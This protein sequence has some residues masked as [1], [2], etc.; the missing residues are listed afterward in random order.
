MRWVSSCSS[1]NGKSFTLKKKANFG[2]YS[3]E[4]IVKK[5]TEEKSKEQ[6][7]HQIFE[8]LLHQ[9]HLIN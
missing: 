8:W 7:D 6:Y 5:L 9:L 1:L 3:K 4:L 2:T